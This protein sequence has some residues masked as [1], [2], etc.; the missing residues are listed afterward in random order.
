MR[1]DVA[2]QRFDLDARARDHFGL[3]PTPTLTELLREVH[4]D[5]RAAIYQ[6]MKAAYA[7]GGAG[8]A[9]VEHRVVRPDG[10]IRWLSVHVRVTYAGSGAVRTPVFGIATSRDI[11]EATRAADDPHASEDRYRRLVENS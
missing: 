8:R 10:E 4:A 11:T 9:V 7:P 2:G 3:G 6:L 1:Y 5:D